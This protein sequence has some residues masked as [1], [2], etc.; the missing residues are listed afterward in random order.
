MINTQRELW[1]NIL[2]LTTS[3]HPLLLSLPSAP[4][5][6]IRVVSDLTSRLDLAYIHAGSMCIPMKIAM[7]W[8]QDR[9]TP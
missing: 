4:D 7:G 3:D 1:S 6:R 8:V 9:D 5:A 2:N